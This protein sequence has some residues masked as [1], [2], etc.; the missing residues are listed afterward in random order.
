MRTL[1]R[2]LI[3]TTAVFFWLAETRCARNAYKQ[4]PID[5]GDASGLCFRMAW[6]DS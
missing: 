3:F 4:I 2:L 1:A 6:R 5:T